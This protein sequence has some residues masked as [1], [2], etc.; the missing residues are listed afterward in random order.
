MKK[1]DICAIEFIRYYITFFK[2]IFLFVILTELI[3]ISEFL[4]MQT[5]Q[6]NGIKF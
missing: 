5:R 2:I 4:V 3:S 6:Q 1:E